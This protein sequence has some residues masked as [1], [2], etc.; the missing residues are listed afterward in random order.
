MTRTASFLFALTSAARLLGQGASAAQDHAEKAVQFV[1]R[2]DL[3]SAESELRIAVEMSPN[4]AALLTSLGGVLGMEGNPR[5]ANAYLTRAVQVNPEDPASRRNLAANEWQLGRLKDAHE[6]LDRLLH[7]NPQDK[8]A[9]FLLGMVSEREQNYAR[10]I[11]LL[12]SIPEI[13]ERQPEALVALASSYY[14]A[15]RAEEGRS[16]LQKLRSLPAKPDVMFMGGRVAIEARDYALA[17]ALFSTIRSTY[18]DAAAVESQLAFAQYRQGHA[19]ASERT[20]AEAIA[21]RHAD[22]PAYLLLCK[23]LAD[24]GAYDQA[25]RVAIEAV[26]ALP[27]SDEALSTEASFEMKLRYFSQ[28]VTSSQRAARLRPCAET[29]R[30]LATAEWRAGARQ[31]AITEFE[32]TIRQF[33]GDAQARVEYGTLLLED[34]SPETK[35]RAIELLKQAIA[36]DDSLVEARYQLAN[37]ELAD[38]K[39][40]PALQYLESAIKLEP[41]DSRLH[42]AISRV[43]RRLGRNSDADQEMVSYQKLKTA[44]HPAT[45]NDSALGTQRP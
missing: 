26:Q 6:N 2:G 7:L 16:L 20:L 39:L 17:E 40:Q 25:L 23:V 29:K 44:E 14:H 41:N 3:K 12:E 28:A 8:I 43:Y 18:P 9:I 38:G 34:G 22:K 36:A 10:S 5:Q 32:Q 30:E 35:G 19:D 15:N 27:D 31:Q 11:T 42:F 33:P 37:I 24:R 21:A 45:P 4:D 13:A 1:Q